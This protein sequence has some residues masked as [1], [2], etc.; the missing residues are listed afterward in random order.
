MKNRTNFTSKLLLA[1][2]LAGTIIGADTYKENYSVN[3]NATVK[4][5]DNF[6]M[7]GDF[8]EIIRFNMIPA[9]EQTQDSK[10]IV[11]KLIQTTKNYIKESKDIRVKLIGHTRGTTDD[12]NE[13]TIDSDT[14]ANKIQNWFRDTL[15]TQQSDEKSKSYA[16]KVYDTLVDNNIS[17]DILVLENRRGEDLAFSDATDEG[18]DLS[19]RVMAIIY[20]LKDKV[21]DKDSDRD[22]VLDSK[23]KC[24]TTPLGEA[25]NKDG[26]PLD[27]DNDGVYDFEDQCP[28][29]AQ[30]LD[31]DSYGC[32]LMRTLHLNFETSS[33]KIL[34]DSYDEVEKFATFMKEHPMYNAEL[35]GHTD[36]VG[37]EEFNMD[38]S[39]RRAISVKN[40]L[41]AQGV[42]A[43]RL[44]A[45]GRGE[46]D[47]VA[48][49]ETP[50]GRLQN[51]RTE[52]IL[53]H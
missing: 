15:T 11:D 47:P 26:C 38:L 33:A 41:V 25:V 36:N 52:V 35:V 8:Q 49:N 32:P 48:S 51:R 10:E 16:Q 19:N 44:K 28:N 21:V 13:K 6:F 29:T 34:E 24:P 31:V 27:S 43:S 53:S 20:V 42:N 50:E 22:G 9:N 2:L 30:N 4:Q 39:K 18:I 17:K 45:F 46:L 5:N 23:D 3:K 37:S 14:Y 12:M 7:D 1:S 40:A